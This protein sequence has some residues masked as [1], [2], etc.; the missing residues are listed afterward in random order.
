MIFPLQWFLGTDPKENTSQ[1]LP[2]KNALPLC[3]A[4]PIAAYTK[5]TDPKENTISA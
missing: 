3:S 5:R 2:E 1:F 4:A